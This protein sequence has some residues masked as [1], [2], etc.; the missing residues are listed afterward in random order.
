MP[1][2]DV[3]ITTRDGLHL[4]G[5]YVRSRNGAAVDG[6]GNNGLDAWG[7][8]SLT[9]DGGT[10]DGNLYGIYLVGGVGAVHLTDVAARGNTFARSLCYE[11]AAEVYVAPPLVLC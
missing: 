6:N 10:Y 3:T 4:A 11:K 7:V 5:W 8:S 9:I 2:A 1:R